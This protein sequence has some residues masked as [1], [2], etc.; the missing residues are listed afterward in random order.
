MIAIV[1]DSSI[2][3]AFLVE[4]W[5]DTNNGERPFIKYIDNRFPQP[6]VSLSA[7]PKACETADFL[8]FA[9]HVQWEK[10]LLSAFTSDYQGVG[11]LLTDPQITSNPYVPSFPCFKLIL[12]IFYQCLWQSIRQR[13][14]TN[15]LQGIPHES[16]VQS[17]LQVFRFEA[18]RLRVPSPFLNV[19][20][21][22]LTASLDSQSVADTLMSITQLKSWLSSHYT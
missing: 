4:E 15:R 7:P 20:T 18:R 5:I 22:L 16:C 2:E 8:V 19:P 6:C 1:Q 9:Q 21:A 17:L 14:P 13:E 11:K 10:S 12:L 3:K